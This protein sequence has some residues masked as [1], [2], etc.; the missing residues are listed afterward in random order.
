MNFDPYQFKGRK[1]SIIFD[2]LTDDG[3]EES[4]ASMELARN[5][6]TN[7]IWKIEKIGNGVLQAA[8]KSSDNKKSFPFSHRWTPPRTTHCSPV[9]PRALPTLAS[10][11]SNKDLA[12]DSFL[13]GSFL[14]D[15]F[16]FED[17]NAATRR[18]FEGFW[19]FSCWPFKRWRRLHSS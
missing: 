16:W 3:S 9:G 19:M 17:F 1:E 11:I 4:I 7:R 5:S 18:Q 2:D 15:L 14:V 10:P 6:I 8:L 12:E 13:I